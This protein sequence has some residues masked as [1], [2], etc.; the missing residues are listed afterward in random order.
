MREYGR[1]TGGNRGHRPSPYSLATQEPVLVHDT[2]E[3]EVWGSSCR[4]RHG[5]TRATSDGHAGTSDSDPDG[6]GGY[7]AVELPATGGRPC[8][9]PGGSIGDPGMGCES[10]LDGVEAD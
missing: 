8:G 10:C 6:D 2:G 9:R 7:G 1:R 5:P 4:P 3:R